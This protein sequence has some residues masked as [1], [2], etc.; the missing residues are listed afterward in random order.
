MTAKRVFDLVVAAV[1]L[2]LT[3]PIVL[4]AMLAIRATSAGQPTRRRPIR[5][6]R[7]ARCCAQPRSTSCRSSGTCSRAR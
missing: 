7:W 6:R 5:S 4:V 2:A 1:M 3:S